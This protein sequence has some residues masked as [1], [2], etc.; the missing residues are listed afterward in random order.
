MRSLEPVGVGVVGKPQDRDVRPGGRDILG[1]HAGDVA[2]DKIRIG[3]GVT[4]HEAMLGEHSFEA[5][6]EEEVDT[7]EQDGRHSGRTYSTLPV[8]WVADAI[9]PW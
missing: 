5:R 6:S 4:R 9:L 8:R 1:V 3:D 2:D 7:G